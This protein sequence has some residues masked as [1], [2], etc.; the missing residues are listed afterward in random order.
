MTPGG[1]IDRADHWHLDVQEVHQ[2]VP[3]FP[4]DAVDPLDRRA[5]REGRG[6]RGRPWP[7]EL[8]TGPSQYDD[9]VVAVGADLV[10]Q[11]RQFAM[12]QKSPTQ[13]LAIRMQSHLQDAVAALHPRRLVLVPVFLERAHRTPP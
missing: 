1:T 12:R 6:P 2:Q 5:G 7:G 11:L 8:C 13:R 10:E 4:M 9:A 3:A